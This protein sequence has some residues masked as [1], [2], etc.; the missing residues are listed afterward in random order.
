MTTQKCMQKMKCFLLF[1][2][3][4]V[5]NQVKILLKH[6]TRSQYKALQEVSVNLLRGGFHL[7]D[8]ELKPLRKHKQF[9]RQL[10]KGSKPRLLQKPIILL[11]KAALRTI[12][13][14]RGNT[15]YTL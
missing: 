1:L 8:E 12:E 9:Y 7:T 3:Q 2:V 14:L 10:A 15:S 6:L 11:L 13:K 5:P 4:T